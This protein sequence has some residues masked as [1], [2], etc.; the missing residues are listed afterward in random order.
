MRVGDRDD[1]GVLS[2]GVRAVSF[3]AFSASYDAR[4]RYQTHK[5]L[6]DDDDDLTYRTAYS[7]PRDIINDDC[8]VVM[9]MCFLLA[10]MN[11]TLYDV[12]SIFFT[13]CT[14]AK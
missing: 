6:C 7:S 5:R 14:V 12:L 1:D 8:R 13:S 10:V 2:I 4:C 3:A 11:T 9:C